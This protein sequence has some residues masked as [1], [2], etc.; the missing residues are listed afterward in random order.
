MN[1]KNTFFDNYIN[2]INV[3]SDRDYSQENVPEKMSAHANYGI[4]SRVQADVA[5]QHALVALLLLTAGIATG[6]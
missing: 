2:I 3:T 4:S 1:D 6:R 5:L